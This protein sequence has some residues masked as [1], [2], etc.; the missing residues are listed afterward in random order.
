MAPQI[1]PLRRPRVNVSLLGKYVDKVVTIIGTVDSVDGSNSK[2]I[3]SDGTINCIS[4]AGISDL[5]IGGVYEFIGKVL[6]D[7]SVKVYYATGQTKPVPAELEMR[8]LKLREG[9]ARE[10][11]YPNSKQEV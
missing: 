9:A 11:F 4:P 2:I 5:A 3:V 7:H 8:L 10:I 6:S 1:N